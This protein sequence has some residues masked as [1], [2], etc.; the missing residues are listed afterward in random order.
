MPITFKQAGIDVR[1]F[2]DKARVG[3]IRRTTAGWVYYPKGSKTGG[4]PNH[5]L[6]AVKRSLEN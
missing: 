5:S 4:E 1:V 2:L 3:T 6:D